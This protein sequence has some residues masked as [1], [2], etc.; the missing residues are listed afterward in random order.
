MKCKTY[1]EFLTK[2]KEEIVVSQLKATLV[3]NCE[4]IQFY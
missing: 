1:Q 2:N 4:L 3:L